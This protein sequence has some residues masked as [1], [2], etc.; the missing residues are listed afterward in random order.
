M[1]KLFTVIVTLPQIMTTCNFHLKFQR[2]S[3]KYTIVS[4]LTFKRGMKE[5]DCTKNNIKIDLVKHCIKRIQVVHLQLI[6]CAIF[7]FAT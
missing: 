7:S 2:Y 1:E 3:E 4:I 6:T 5:T